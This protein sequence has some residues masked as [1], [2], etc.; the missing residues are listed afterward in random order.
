MAP[1]Y[2]FLIA[3]TYFRQLYLCKKM[4]HHR[5]SEYTEKTGFPFGGRYHQRESSQPFGQGP[6]MI[7]LPQARWFCLAG[8]SLQG[9]NLLCVLCA[10]SDPSSAVACY[11]GWKRVVKE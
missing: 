8:I 4:V 2:T 10:S 7:G 11:G 9:K 3:M 5:G 6:V 1:K